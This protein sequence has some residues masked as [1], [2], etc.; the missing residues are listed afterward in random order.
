[1]RRHL[2]RILR[3]LPFKFRNR[4]DESKIVSL[5]QRCAQTSLLPTTPPDGS[6]P[7]VNSG[8]CQRAPA[9]PG[10][11]CYT[12][13]AIT[14]RFLTCTATSGSD[15]SPLVSSSVGGLNESGAGEGLRSGGRTEIEADAAEI[16]AIDA[17]CIKL[18][19]ELVEQWNT[20]P[21]SSSRYNSI[22]SLCDCRRSIAYRN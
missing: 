1:M 7:A 13:Y 9:T 10:N 5:V 4:L 15:E 12:K 19:K 11:D 8:D 2:L 22:L 18:S 14:A 3:I 16:A 17:E 20:L 6:T 21:V